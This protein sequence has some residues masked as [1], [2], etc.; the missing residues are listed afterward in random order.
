MRS[1]PRP[2]HSR[3]FSLGYRS[4]DLFG[5][6]KGQ[7][8]VLLAPDEQHGLTR[9]TPRPV[10]RLQLLNW[11][12]TYRRKPRVQ[13]TLV[14]FEALESLHITRQERLIVEVRAL[15]VRVGPPLS[16]EPSEVLAQA[17]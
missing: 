6:R 1:M 7:D 2:L 9:I 8:A 5:R 10:A 3:Q 4:P 12:V 15:A 14:P 13:S 16:S 11:K 17:W